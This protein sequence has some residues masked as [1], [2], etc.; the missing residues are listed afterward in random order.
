GEALDCF[1]A[2][3]ADARATRDTPAFRRHLADALAGDPRI[4]QYWHL[5]AELTGP[6]TPGAAHDWL[7]TALDGEVARAAG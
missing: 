6:E 2:A 7:C 4:D 1:V 3:Y 5:V